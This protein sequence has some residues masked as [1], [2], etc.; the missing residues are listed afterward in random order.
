MLAASWRREDDLAG[1]GLG[2]AHGS[3]KRVGLITNDQ[4]A[5]LVDTAALKDRGLPV[6]EV[7][8]GCFC[9]KFD[10]LVG[11]MDV[12]TGAEQPDALLG[13]PVGS[14][15]DLSATVIQPLKALHSD[16]YRLAP[17]TVLV[18]P[19]RVGEV[20]GL[21]GPAAPPP[22]FPDDVNYIFRGAA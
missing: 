18:D 9:C 7:S 15:T 1:D 22:G 21:S 4:A 12:L 3:G 16:R 6:E 11:A 10:D 14:C 8:G 2:A 17:F 13:E 19:D 5:N 20:L